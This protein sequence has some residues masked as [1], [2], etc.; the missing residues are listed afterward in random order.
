MLCPKCAEHPLDLTF[1]RRGVWQKCTACGY[2]N[3]AKENYGHKHRNLPMQPGN[4]AATTSKGS[5]IQGM[6]DHDKLGL[7]EE[8]K[9]GSEGALQQILNELTGELTEAGWDKK[10]AR[11]DAV[12]RL[13]T[14]VVLDT[15]AEALPLDNNARRGVSEAKRSKNARFKESWVARAVQ[16]MERGMKGPMQRLMQD[17]ESA[18]HIR[19]RVAWHLRLGV[20]LLEVEKERLRRMGL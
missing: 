14:R 2:V 20:G 3:L 5:E 17:E 1:T 11:L 6:K 4:S 7:I 18:R 10:T 9:R 12:S 15:L 13:A 16:G 19:L 8:M